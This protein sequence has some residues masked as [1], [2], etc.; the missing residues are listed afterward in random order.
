[1][2]FPFFTHLTVCPEKDCSSVHFNTA[3]FSLPSP[4]Y[5]N[6]GA[7]CADSTPPGAHAEMKVGKKLEF[8]L[9]HTQSVKAVNVQ[10]IQY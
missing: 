9:A 4:Y 8:Q 7:V 6:S 10:E 3:T 1:M 2:L 5:S